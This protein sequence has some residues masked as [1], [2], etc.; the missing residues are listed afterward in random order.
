MSQEIGS[1]LPPPLRF[2]LGAQPS[3]ETG[4]AVLFLSSDP[5]GSHRVAVLAPSQLE[6]LDAGRIVV[7]LA[8][9]SSTQANVE[10]TGQGALWYVLDAAAYCIRGTT[11]RLP[12][13]ESDNDAAVYELTITSVLR[14]FDPSGPMVSGPTY[15]RMESN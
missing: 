4:K 15:R 7:R 5:S 14:D 12:P 10:R 6:V 3:G 9:T 1:N 13:N 2:E 8:A 11:K